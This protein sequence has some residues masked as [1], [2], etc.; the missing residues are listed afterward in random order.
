MIVCGSP[1]FDP[2]DKRKHTIT[3]PRAVFETLSPSTETR[4][5]TIKFDDYRSMDGFEEYVLLSQVEPRVETYFRMSD[6]KW[7][8]DVRVGL[9]ETVRLQSVGIDLP[10]AELYAGVTFPPPDPRDVAR[11]DG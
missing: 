1:I 10:L 6:G 4:D 2:D 11:S 5:R 8:F 3:N 7:Q 9:D